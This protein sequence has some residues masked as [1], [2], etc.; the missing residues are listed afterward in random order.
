[1]NESH[2]TEG[3]V[4]THEGYRLEPGSFATGLIHLYRAEV[5]RANLWR[6]RLDTTTNWAVV[7]TAAALTFSF[8]SPDNPHFVLL[9]VL[10]LALTFLLIEARRYAYYALWYH[11]AR[12]LETDFFAAM[13]SPPF[14]PRDGWADSLNR[15]LMDPTFLVPRWRAV[16]IRYRRNY[17]WI[18][19]IILMSWILKLSVH[20]TPIN[21]I[22]MIS[23]RAGINGWLPGRY[24][25]AIIGTL[26]VALLGL[27]VIAGIVHLRKGG[28][29]SRPKRYHRG[30][31]DVQ[32]VTGEQLAIIVTDHKAKVSSAVMSA[33]GRGVTALEGTGMY[34]GERRDVLFCALKETQVRRL[35]NAVKEADPKAFMVLTGARDVR[36]R[37]FAPSAQDEPPS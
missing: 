19:T 1:M 7:T 29:S 31:L 18:V 35:H 20:P 24:V 11:R 2:D 27:V 23:E 15:T 13:V 37:G 6:S 28:E 3:Q 8:S 16:A 17:V 14:E 30:P 32:T 26:Y 22:A 34:T 21:N 10:L 5:S 36:G 25:F 4:W 33:T 12:L 9:L